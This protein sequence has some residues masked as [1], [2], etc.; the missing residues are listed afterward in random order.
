MRIAILTSVVASCLWATHA[1]AQ[2]SQCASGGPSSTE[3]ENLSATEPSPPVADPDARPEGARRQHDF[4]LPN[5]NLVPKGDF[6]V[7]VHQLTAYNEIRYGLS[8]RVELMAGAPIYPVFISLGGRV[9]AAPLKSRFRLLFGATAWLPFIDDDNGHRRFWVQ[10]AST[11]A[12]HGDS[13]N[14]HATLSGA[15]HSRAGIQLPAANVGVN[16]RIKR[17]IAGHINYASLN[18]TGTWYCETCTNP[19]INGL[20]LGLKYMSSDWET[21]FGLTFLW[22]PERGFSD[23]FLP[24]PML[25]IRRL[26]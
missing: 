8:D 13:F 12:Y 19:R 5:G 10:A 7:T 9:Q 26:Y 14:V 3:C 6:T 15:V 11:I 4:F 2:S 25:S 22:D 16:I 24:I 21:D 20:L 17:R 18:T 23:E 1:S